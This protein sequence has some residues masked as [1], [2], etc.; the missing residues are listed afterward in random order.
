MKKKKIFAVLA[1]ML[2]LLVLCTMF[3]FAEESADGTEAVWDL[4]ALLNPE[5]VNYAQ[6]LAILVTSLLTIIK[7]FSGG[8]LKELW[9]QLVNALKNMIP[10]K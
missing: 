2:T 8:N 1:C 9:E 4:W 6:V 3:A 7:M 5:N 10:S